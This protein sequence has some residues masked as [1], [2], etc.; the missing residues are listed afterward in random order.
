MGKLIYT[1]LTSIDGFIS[2]D[3]GNFDWAEPRED[4][5]SFINN[6]ELQNNTLLLG[7]NMYE[8]LTFWE[9]VPDL[10][11]QPQY[12]QDYQIAWKKM[13]KIVFSTSLEKTTTTNTILKKVFDKPEIEKLKIMD[14]NNIGIG[15]AN[16]ASQALSF[17]LIDEI[18][19]FIFPIM[20]GT[21]KKWLKSSQIINFER[22]DY[23]EFLNGVIMLH[24]KIQ[25]R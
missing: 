10:K 11:K 24:Y 18:I 12:I 17:G 22:I 6:L 21:G 2:D 13:N 4:V 19:Q 25:N 9:N 14:S 20:I 3:H 1:A 23:K 7:K 5:H 16:I 8:I 15:G